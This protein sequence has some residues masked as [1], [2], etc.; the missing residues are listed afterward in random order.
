MKEGIKEV[1]AKEVIEAEKGTEEAV[2]QILVK[3][4]EKEKAQGMDAIAHQ[5]GALQNMI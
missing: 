4:A 3:A 1:T 2:L 5:E